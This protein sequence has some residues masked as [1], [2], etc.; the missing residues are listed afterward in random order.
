[1]Q[2]FTAVIDQQNGCGAVVTA[3]DQSVNPSRSDRFSR[4]ARTGA[5]S[6]FGR[7]SSIS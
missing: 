3:N 4:H 5:M 2:P 7:D 1:M 6:L